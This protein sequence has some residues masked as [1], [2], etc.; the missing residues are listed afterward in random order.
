[1]AASTAAAGDL[2]GAL[3]RNYDAAAKLAQQQAAQGKVHRESAGAARLTA[4]EMG[5]LASVMLDTAS[6]L[7]GG[8]S[9]FLILAQQGLQA[10]DAVGGVS[11][12]MALLASPTAPAVMGAAVVAA[13][14]ALIADRA[15]TINAQTRELNTTMRAYG[16]TA[17]AT[18]GQL[19]D[20]SKALY[21]GGA[22]RDES[23]ATAKVLA[24]TRGV[25]PTMGRELA[26]LG[27]DMAAGLGGKV[28]DTVKDLTKLATEGYPA[29]AKLQEA[30]G[31]LTPAEMEAVR[32]MSEH[33]Q[34]S[35]ALGVALDALHRRFDGLR[36][37]SM[38]P[39]SA[40]MHELGVQFNRLVDV[41]ATSPLVVSITAA[42]SDAFRDVADF[43]AN[44]SLEGFGKIA[45][46]GAYAVAP[47]PTVI[48]SYIADKFFGPED[49]AALRKRLEDA[50]GKVAELEANDPFGRPRG[51]FRPELEGA[52]AE[53][54][55][56]ES[57]IEATAGKAKAA[58]AT[59]TPAKDPAGASVTGGADED[60]AR[61]ALQ[62]K[63]QDY[64]DA[65]AHAIDRLSK[66]LRGNAVD[67]A[68]ATAAMKA[69]DEISEKRLEGQNTENLRI[70]RRRE[71][72]FQLEVAVN[73]SNRAAAAEVAGTDLVARAYGQSTAAVREAEIQSKALTEVARGTIE[74]YDAI[75]TRLRS[76]DDAQRKVQAASFDATLKQQAEDANRLAVAWGSG[77]DAAREAGLANE[78]LAEARKRGLDP[79]RDAGQ[80]RDIGAGILARDAAQRSQQFA[81]MAA[82]QRRAVDLANAEYDT[83]GQ[84][85][86][87]RAKTLA[88][89]QT[90][91]ELRDKGVDLT[92]AGT[93][94]Y[95]RQAGELAR[96]KSQMQD[97]AQD[98]AKVAQPIATAFED[99]I[100]G[101]KKAGDA[102]K[103]L[104]EELRRVFVNMFITKPAE[105]WLTG[106]LTKLMAGPI[107]PV[108]DNT[109]KPAID[110]AAPDRIATSVSRGLGSSSNAMWVRMAGSATAVALDPQA[111]TGR[112][113][114]VAV[115]DGKDASIAGPSATDATPL[116]VA[117]KSAA[118]LEGM[119]D[120]IA[121]KYGLDA[122]L[123]KA[124]IT[125]ES[126][127]NPNVVNPRTGA[128]GLGQVMPANWKAYGITNPF[129]AQQNLEASARILREHLDR[130]SGDVSKALSTYSGHIKTSGDAYVSAV[131]ATK[132]AYDRGAAGMETA[133]L[134]TAGVTAAQERALQVQLDA[135]EV[136]RGAT[137]STQTLT[138]TQQSWVDSALGLTSAT[139][140]A[141]GVIEVHSRAVSHMDENA[142]SAADGLAQ[143]G[144]S[145][146]AFGN[147]A[148]EGADTFLGGIS[149]MLGGADDWLGDLFGSSGGQQ[150]KVIK[151]ADGST[152]FAPAA[153]GA[154]GSW[155]SSPVFGQS[156]S[157]R[158]NAG[159]V[160][161]MPGTAAEGIG[162]W[163]PSWGQVL[164]G[165]GGVASGAM[166]ATQ[167]G[168]TA[169]Q[170][171]G[172]GLTAAGG[173]V[174]MIPGAQIVGGVMMAAGALL[175]A[176]TGAKDRGEKYSISH[177][178]LQGSGKYALGA[179]A[180]DNDGDP[181]RFNAD[182][183]KVAKGLNDIVA[184][185]NL[186]PTNKDSYI[187]SKN[188]SA[189]QAALELLK[190]MKSGV[191]EIAYAIA[192]ESAAS[193]EDML[194]HLDFAN[195]FNSQVR[196]LRSSISDLFSQFQTGVE[197]GNS[198]GRM[199]VQF[200]DNAQTVFAVS[201]GAK[202]P[203]F[204]H[205]TLSAPS[206]WAVVGEEGP[207]VV[208]LAGGERIWNARES[209]RML[210][211]QGLGAD[212][213]L[214]HV[215]PDELAW[216]QRT[217]GGGRIN[218]TTGLPM[219][220][221]G[222][223]GG[224]GDTGGHSGGGH[225][226]N[227]SGTMGGEN[228]A[229]GSAYGSTADRDAAYGGGWGTSSGGGGVVDTI[230]GW[231]SAVTGWMSELGGWQADTAEN[232]QAQTEALTAVAGLTPAAVAAALSATAQ[233]AGTGLT[234][235]LEALTG[236][237]G[238]A[239][240]VSHDYGD[241]TSA[242]SGTAG[243]IG[244]RAVA[245]SGG[246]GAFG[247]FQGASAREIDSTLSALAAALLADP[248]G[249][250]TSEMVG[251]ARVGDPATGG[252][253]VRELADNPNWILRF[254]VGD[255]SIALQELD[256]AAQQLLA[257]TGAI[258]EVLQRAL[259]GANARA[260][261]LGIPTATSA[262][263]VQEQAERD[264][265]E[266]LNLQFNAVGLVRDR[267]AELNSIV[268]SLGNN[269]FSPIGKDFD[270][271]AGDMRKAADA[272]VAAGQ[273]VPDGLY[274][275]MKQMETLGAVKKRLLDEVAGVT[276]ESSPEQQK[277]EQLRGKWSNTATDLVK[278]FNSVGIVGDE[279]AAKLNEGFGNAL[280]KE[281][282]S[283][284]DSL[285]TAFRKSKGEEG[286]DSAVGLI[287]AYKTSVK[288]VNAL[289]PEGAER[290]A[291]MG[292]VTGTLT[293][294]MEGLVK[295]GS[296][297]ST[298]LREI[299]AAFSDTPE[300]VNAATVALKK[301]DD[302]TAE[303]VKTF[304]SGV[305]ARMYAAVGNARSSGLISLDEQQRQELKTAQEAG[306]DT[307]QLQ[308]VQGAERGQKAFELAQADVVA[309]Y[310]QEINARQTF[311]GEL[312]DGALKV[313]QAAKQF[314]A[315]RD[316]LAISQD[317]PISPQE[318]LTETKRQWDAAL[319]TVRSTT[320]SDEDKDSARSNLISLGQNLVSIE[321]EN[322]AGTARTLYDMVLAVEKELGT[323]APD[324]TAATAEADLKVAQDSLKELQK[325]RTEAASIGQR[326]LG[327]LDELKNTM[328]QSLAIWQAALDPLKS[329]TGSNDNAPHTST[330]TRYSASSDVQAAWDRLTSTQQA[331][332]ARSLGWGG[333]VD[334]AFNYWLGADTGRADRFNTAVLQ[335][336]PVTPP[337]TAEMTADQKRQ[338][339]QA[340]T[341]GEIEQYFGGFADIQA[342]RARN[343]AFNLAEWFQ[344]FG[345]DEVLNGSRHIPG[346]AIGTL[347]TPPGAVWVGERGPE[348]LWQAGG[349]AVASSADSMRIAGM[350]QT[351]AN[352]SRP[353]S[354]APIRPPAGPLASDNREILAVLRDIAR[355]IERLET[356]IHEA[357]GEAQTQRSRIAQDE[358]TLMRQQLDELREQQVKRA[359]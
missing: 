78:A 318:R 70:E 296:I 18:A 334:Q 74:P 323:V 267:V 10:V 234:G 174:S 129:D 28:D 266:K 36:K 353:P 169:G 134:A 125:R 39:A 278:A 354:V 113:E 193:L 6:Q 150:Q 181:T 315:A 340:F 155:L 62:A 269:T 9:P 90:T 250:L 172:G 132:G 141:S 331:D 179:S 61:K 249:K 33:G 225:N 265:A 297:T 256:T 206:G 80:I 88:V 112:P 276:V 216:M 322:S 170:K 5:N 122:S 247:A 121:G 73:D 283:Y 183:S 95:I 238:T 329:L 76:L 115:K 101:A 231:V 23:F 337:L 324:S 203:G 217:L 351:V 311:I 105:T 321:K 260:A 204:S 229:T 138:T 286:Y 106:T 242:I 100:L 308:L 223:T 310:D 192:H 281:Q 93:Q 81:Q 83:L 97:A 85:N 290:A 116:P 274:G 104:A 342:E 336:V 227:G 292:K 326:Q 175:S 313:A 147:A 205:G 55:S 287:D 65:Q 22:G 314:A 348:L 50:K 307:T 152:S 244:E 158:P 251:S 64:V 294:N 189:E 273:S 154:G 53:V 215:R 285:D 214:V 145:A 1:M 339:L 136:Q 177:I 258:P 246:R 148:G 32:T 207:E 309:W 239:A 345:I 180:Q 350:Y 124:V 19:R 57:R 325:A 282:K 48:G 123:F 67:R 4:D 208:R 228:A 167:K 293:N 299:I 49:E 7:G 188:K 194:S 119:A 58:A 51:A 213:E 226:S 2:A 262:R 52:R 102:G 319:S 161:P 3:D 279:L 163:N 92:D 99:V 317:A 146:T 333:S 210:A 184:R 304:D 261:A 301:L 320:A 133:S 241:H 243:T 233:V 230:S 178:T 253:S 316:A 305:S 237:R 295:S 198:L 84:S 200:V 54:A 197:A 26:L 140:D 349:A 277:V 173:V 38:S 149:K 344:R 77:A 338:R 130:A 252:I 166:M 86:A 117:I 96:F 355:R 153:R 45:K 137:D 176:V 29:I 108:N 280:K 259:D 232:T 357:E 127:W 143:A 72:L 343:P 63:G 257:A 275:A 171:I 191:P 43:I 330:P 356:S 69:E 298:S 219:F 346:F 236:E 75:V 20:V 240:A 268:V 151:N 328:G 66:S 109:P 59:A 270:A 34:Q 168:A 186:T 25:S 306:R 300:V 14:L 218:P 118:G 190:G 291:Q 182:A 195:S 341:T 82:E 126:S 352:D 263:Q 120:Q 144:D 135:I 235:M 40:A 131:M 12:A 17:Q 359:A 24:S 302:A 264:K 71:A 31:F 209:A 98:A 89:L 139:K 284:S 358:I 254:E 91:N 187:D 114:P 312:Q 79:S 16:T 8:Q 110:P 35:E 185:L 245:A 13:G 56:L 347:S 44:P 30:I 222:G 162:G 255:P 160:G 272:Y 202:L 128:A 303:A 37:D 288:D 156:E 224:V 87:E 332:I 27:S 42:V 196:S 103:A 157:A 165:V 41:F 327:S 21:E 94:A 111:M 15:I 107:D 159:F 164:Q 142:I 11:R 68:L 289:W 221:E 212:T 220:L 211:A 60:A 335:A 201:S 271:L 248:T 47:G 199:L 46:I